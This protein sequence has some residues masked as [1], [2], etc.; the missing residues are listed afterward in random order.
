M[1]SLRFTL[2]QIQ[3]NT[4]GK[5]YALFIVCIL[6][7]GSIM[8]IADCSRTTSLTTIAAVNTEL[9]KSSTDD[10]APS[11]GRC[12]LDVMSLVINQYLYNISFVERM[13]VSYNNDERYWKFV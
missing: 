1:G 9:R 13:R 10:E 7:F 2:L 5:S 11:E 3:N 8:S 6:C 12:R 4:R